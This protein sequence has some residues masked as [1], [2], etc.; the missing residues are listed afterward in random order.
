[1]PPLIRSISQC[2][3]KTLG[4]AYPIIPT[5]TPSTLPPKWNQSTKLWKLV[6]SLNNP[7]ESLLEYLTLDNNL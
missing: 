1:M 5:F 2:K 6:T 4:N 3:N 7:V